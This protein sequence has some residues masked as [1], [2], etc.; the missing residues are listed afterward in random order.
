MR[1]ALQRW[2]WLVIV[3]PAGTVFAAEPEHG[4]PQIITSYLSLRRILQIYQQPIHE[5]MHW[6]G[7]SENC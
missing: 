4:L 5:L 6:A 7:S 3:L 1:A 2:L